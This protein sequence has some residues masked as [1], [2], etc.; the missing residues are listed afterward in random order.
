MVKPKEMPTILDSKK[1]EIIELKKLYSGYEGSQVG[2][3]FADGTDWIL[4]DDLEAIEHFMAARDAQARTS[5]GTS[6][7]EGWTRAGLNR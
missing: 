2:M 3:T 7:A 6:R 1:G 5:K 4:N